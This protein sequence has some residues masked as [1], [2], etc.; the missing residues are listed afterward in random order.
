MA[1]RLKDI[2]KELNLSVVTISKV[3]RDHPDI[4]A[5]TRERVLQ[6]M[7]A[8]NYRPNLAARALVTG[9][10]Y[11]AGLIVPD[12]VHPFFGEVAKS[13][14]NVL[15][16]RGYSLVLSSSEDDPQLEE[17]EIE[18]LLARRVDV[19][20]VAS[21]QKTGASFRRIQEQ[22]T[23]VVLIDRKFE[24]LVT[25]FVGIDDVLAGGI[26]TEHLLEVGCRHLAFIGGPDVSTA[27]G[28]LRGYRDVLTRRKIRQR[29]ETIIV[30]EHGDDAGDRSGY[31]AMQRLLVLKPRPDGLF[32]YN[33]PTAMGAMKAVLDAGLRIPEDVAIV[34]CGNVAYADFLRVPLTSVDQQSGEIG[35]RAAKL[36][37]AVL[38][39]PP[40]RA[41]QIVLTPQ[42]V[43]RASTRR[44]GS[45]R[46]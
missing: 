35:K 9:H 31:D 33:D 40:N 14:S 42:L 21:V 30:R 38:E 7:K 23:P 10:T 2:A 6:R 43:V 36:A 25:H 26:A 1:A 24:D 15:R 13:L 28:R 22:K 3:L 16:T 27:A 4:G 41:K 8:L 17:Q 19:L 32:C 45:K 11:A 29:P 34:G 12:L 37:L 18:Q 20:V 46:S 39:T 44:S 5:Q